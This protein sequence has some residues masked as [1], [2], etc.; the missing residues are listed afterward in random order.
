V[1]SRPSSR[2]VIANFILLVGCIGIALLMVFARPLAGLVAPGFTSPNEVDTL[3]R[4]TRII[5]PAQLFH[6]I[7]GLLSAALP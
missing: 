4:L 5:L 1:L 7:G 3:V 2:C 6:V